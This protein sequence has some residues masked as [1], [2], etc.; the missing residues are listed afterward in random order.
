ML[1]ESVSG[2]DE[3]KKA[4]VVASVGFAQCLEIFIAPFVV[5]YEVEAAFPVDR[6][7]PD[8][9]L[10]ILVSGDARMS[11]I[12]VREW[13]DLHKAMMKPRARFQRRIG[14]VFGPIARIIEK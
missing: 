12:T 8:V 1:A 7:V 2:S 9:V 10:E 13:M 14:A 3:R 4:C 6:P 5:A 11:P